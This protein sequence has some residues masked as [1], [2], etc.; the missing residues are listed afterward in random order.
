MIFAN[1]AATLHRV[2]EK[3]AFNLP[4]ADGDRERFLA[5][6]P[7]DETIPLVI[8]DGVWSEEVLARNECGHVILAERSPEPRR[9]PKGSCVSFEV[10]LSVVR[11][12]ICHHD[13]CADPGE[14]VAPAGV[15]LPQGTRNRP[16]EGSIIFSGALPMTLAASGIPPWMEVEVGPNYA[17]LWGTPNV[18]GSWPIS[19]AASGVGLVVQQGLVEVG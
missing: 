12:E 14:P 17:R 11:H 2:L 19:V 4:L 5:L 16:W 13:C 15:I 18:R 9:F 8:R 3:D 7:E 6:V 1:F 10:T